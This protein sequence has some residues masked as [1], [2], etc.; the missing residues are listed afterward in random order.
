MEEQESTSTSLIEQSQTYIKYH[1]RLCNT[2]TNILKIQLTLGSTE[3]KC[4]TLATAQSITYRSDLKL[5][6]F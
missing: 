6:G 1:S 2:N 4:M 5:I 3:C